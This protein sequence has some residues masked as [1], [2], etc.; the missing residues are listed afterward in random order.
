MAT[1]HAHYRKASPRDR[2]VSCANDF[3]TPSSA[4][5]WQA[6]VGCSTVEGTSELI[7]ADTTGLFKLWDLRNFQCIQTFT[8]EHESGDLDDLTGTLNCFAHLKLPSKATPLDY[9]RHIDDFRNVAASKKLIY[10][11]QERVRQE[12]CRIT[13]R[14]VPPA[15]MSS[16][17]RFSPRQNEQQRSGTRF[18]VLS[19]VSSAILHFRT[20][21][22]H[23][24]TTESASLF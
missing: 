7:T 18:S 9:Q 21:R 17:L 8:S 11:D 4:F 5:F 22:R 14:F 24:W 1:M 12:P 10:F 20:Y 23:V 6:L 15:I 2:V 16:P 3:R 19:N 13:G